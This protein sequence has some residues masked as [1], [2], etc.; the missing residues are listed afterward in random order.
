MKLIKFAP[1]YL[2]KLI[3]IIIYSMV[4]IVPLIIWNGHT[5]AIEIKDFFIQ[6]IIVLL[7][8]L[9]LLILL[10]RPNISL[11]IYK[12]DILIVL[13]VIFI[14]ASYLRTNGT[15]LNYK[16]ILPQITG[17][18]FFYLMRIYIKPTHIKNILFAVSI[19]SLICSIYGI[20]Q[21]LKVDP[22][23][24]DHLKTTPR[25]VST[26]GHKNYFGM[27]LIL[28]LPIIIYSLIVTKNKIFKVLFAFSLIISYLALMVSNCRGAFII[29]TILGILIPII[30]FNKL[31]VIFNF[32]NK[33][34]TALALLPLLLLIVAIATPAEIKENIKKIITEKQYQDRVNI[35]IASLEV[36][37]N[38]PFL[39][40]GNGNFLISHVKNIH[41]KYQY[42]Q[43][44]QLLDHCHN[45]YIEILLESG[46]FAFAIYLLLFLYL[47]VRLFRV[48]NK[49]E[50]R[51][52][53]ILSILLFWSLM[54]FCL[55][56]L[57]DIAPRFSSTSLF[58]WLTIALFVILIENEPYK[59]ININ[60]VL[61]K[62]RIFT[63]LIAFVIIFSASIL[64]VK[65]V[66]NCF[67]DHY[68]ELANRT[69][70][71][72][73]KIQYLNEAV[74]LQPKSIEAIYQRGYLEFQLDNI[75]NS[76]S[77][78]KKI[79]TLAPNYINI[80][81][82]IASCYYKIGSFSEAKLYLLK[83]ISLY[84]D[85]LNSIKLL[86]FVSFHQRNINDAMFY[87]NQ[88]LQKRPDDKNVVDLKNQLIAISRTN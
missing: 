56:S 11:R 33:A 39:G 6:F 40:V 4:I 28:T 43:P 35:Y 74:K 20:L 70:D 38:N 66:S 59:T 45:E 1:E 63:G 31:K 37:S 79:D 88:Y 14:L 86:S 46:I 61:V 5:T 8:T 62:N 36:V 44:I 10:L 13:Y 81:H 76:L 64:F 87:C 84:P 60:N 9:T 30:S 24:W 85:H 52:I 54:A 73:K 48:R 12:I 57:F 2:D 53:T 26:F 7:L 55:Y 58:L 49:T 17:I 42:S 78:Y 80:N 67:S 71:P 25:S 21:F 27:F 16:A 68:L 23:V 41:H 15:S 3:R 19:V 34:I 22:L 18:A 29:F 83:S 69:N 51:D 77:D 65:I 72:P 50:N 75:Q 82:N 32:R 47:L